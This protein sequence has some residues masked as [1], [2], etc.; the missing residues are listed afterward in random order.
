MV[1]QQWHINHQYCTDTHLKNDVS[2]WN[3]FPNMC[4]CYVLLC[5]N[6][7]GFFYDLEAFS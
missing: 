5:Q 7:G 1:H 6:A 2:F 3:V 4:L